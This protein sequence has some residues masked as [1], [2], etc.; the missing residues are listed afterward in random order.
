MIQDNYIVWKH[1]EPIIQWCCII[2]Q[3]NWCLSYAA[4][5]T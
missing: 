2:S 1:Q 4:V 5:E 3:T